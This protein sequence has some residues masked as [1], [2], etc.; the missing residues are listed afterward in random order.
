MREETNCSGHESKKKETGKRDKDK[1][2]GKEKDKD[3]GKDKDKDKDKGKGKDKSKDR[4]KGPMKP[5]IVDGT[6][7]WRDRKSEKKKKH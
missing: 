2:K 3:K 1:D 5:V 4:E 6:S 7:N